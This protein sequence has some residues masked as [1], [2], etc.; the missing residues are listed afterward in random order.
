MI[1]LLRKGLIFSLSILFI[2]CPESSEDVQMLEIY[3]N[4]NKE[5]WQASYGTMIPESYLASII[6]L[7]TFPIGNRRSKRFEEHVYRS[8]LDLKYLGKNFAKIPQ[9]K[10][11]YL[12][13]QE[14]KLYATSYGLTQMMGFHCL[15]IGCKIDELMGPYQLQ[16]AV[17]WM[18]K[19]YGHYA[20][21]GRFSECFRI[22][23]T[24]RP[25]GRTH[26]HDYVERGLKRMNYYTKWIRRS[27]SLF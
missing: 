27:G 13:D 2:A 25:T 12:N 7:E 22:H 10:V 19:N 4:M 18:E 17:V 15:K 23:N 16:W 26:R 11:K 6:S 24:G 21:L 1:R 20:R 8:L 5:I 14:L 3:R 9:A